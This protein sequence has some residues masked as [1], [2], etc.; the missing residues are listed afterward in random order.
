M[1]PPQWANGST[2]DSYLPWTASQSVWNT[3]VSRYATFVAALAERYK[4][5][6]L[7]YE[8]W[9]EPNERYFWHPR[10]ETNVTLAI[11]RY[12]QLFTAAKNAIL[13]KDPVAKVALG[14]ITGSGAGC[15]IQGIA[16]IEGLMKND[17]S[18]DYAGIHPYDSNDPSTHVNYQQNYDDAVAV[19]R[20]IQ[21]YPAY[22]NVRLWFTETANYD[23]NQ[24]G[25][26]TQANYID[27]IMRRADSGFEGRIPLGVIEMVHIFLDRDQVGFP[28][29]GLFRS[30][31]TPKQSAYRMRTY[32]A[33]RTPAQ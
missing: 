18:F 29:A 4:G 32:L 16:F 23:S 11:S 5:K 6:N 15:C 19:Y 2:D 30:I 31:G 8:I 3:F 10:P 13:S 24:L 21:Q 1:R 17:V 28:G 9:N 22:R 14:G 33:G 12:G 25:E 7:Y 20:K 27:T 26:N